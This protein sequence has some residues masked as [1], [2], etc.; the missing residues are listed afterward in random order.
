[1]KNSERL[2]VYFE[3]SLMGFLHRS[4]T[5]AM[6][7]EYDKKWLEKEDAI[8]LSLSLGLEGEK[9]TGQEVY[10]FFENLLPDNL[11][12]RKKIAT[13]IQADS[14]SPFDLL[15]IIGGDCIGA[16]RMLTSQQAGYNQKIQAS[17]ITES[18]ISELIKNLKT[19][20]LGIKSNDKYKDFR[21]SVAGAQEKT[22]LL[23]HDKQWKIPLGT[24]PTTHLFK[25]SMGLLHNGID[26]RTSVENEWLCLKI[27]E[28][29]GLNVNKAEIQKFKDVSCLVVERFDRQWKGKNKLMRTPQEDMCQALGIPTHLKYEADYRKNTGI[30]PGIKD[31]LNLLNES[32]QRQKDRI[33]F[34]RA[35]IVYWLLGAID[36]HGKNFSIQM[37]P[38]AFK[39]T[40]C[41]DVLSVYPALHSKQIQKKQ[42]KMAMAIGDKRH[43]KLFDIEPR[44]FFE[45]AKKMGVPHDA[46]DKIFREILKKEENIKNK[47]NVPKGFPDEVFESILY[48]L[49]D[50]IAR[51]K[52]HYG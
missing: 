35:N 49:I 46:I 30:R 31:I 11:E 32:D 3:E 5:G 43:Y 42:A 1:M 29:F 48:G 25:P 18:E 45:T 22:A 39:M 26:L 44:H 37:T 38:S 52:L 2:W 47:I 36:G 20:P 6:S 8:P 33:E 16:L 17:P 50:R 27:C 21:I 51:I 23:Y 4:G 12:I 41:Y 14:H 28:Y 15:K 9:Y 13:N 10:N 7:F 40:P 24:T 19:Q 34:M